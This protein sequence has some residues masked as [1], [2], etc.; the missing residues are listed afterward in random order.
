MVVLRRCAHA[1]YVGLVSTVLGSSCLSRKVS[2]KRTWPGNRQL[3]KRV[4]EVYGVGC[5]RARRR[6]GGY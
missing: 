1:M 2:T 4:G 3:M 6:C 5:R